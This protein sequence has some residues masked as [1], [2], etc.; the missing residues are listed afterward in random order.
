MLA[1][2]AAAPCNEPFFSEQKGRYGLSPEHLITNGPFKLASQTESVI[3]LRKNEN[4]R[5]LALSDS[6]YVYINR[7]DAV[8]LFLENRSDLCLVPF[9]RQTSAL[10]TGETFYNASWLLLFS[11][12]GIFKD[13]CDLRAALVGAL[14][15]EP[16]MRLPPDIPPAKGL[17]PPDSRILGEEYRTLAGPLS[18]PPLVQDPRKLFFEALEGQNGTQ[19]PK[20]TLL[21]SDDS[22]DTELGGVAQRIWQEKLSVYF[23]LEPLSLASLTAR[24]ASGRFDVAIAPLPSSGTSPADMLSFFSSIALDDCSP[25]KDSALPDESVDFESSESTEIARLLHSA[26]LMTDAKA[27]AAACLAVEQ[28]IADSY[29]ASPIYDAPSLFARR[30]GVSGGEYLPATQ[31]VLFSSVVRIS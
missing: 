29:L 30:E 19:L 15:D 21:V 23:N 14:G 13:K 27:A 25:P 2:S 20:L 4:H 5:S 18:P 16:F 17:I 24:I 6:V 12:S 8:S 3:T 1:L 10:Q 26:S 9:Q 7:G 11:P 22:L 31:V 28:I